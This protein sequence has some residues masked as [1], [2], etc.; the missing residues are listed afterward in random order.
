M[1]TL[2]AWSAD[3]DALAAW[4]APRLE[5]LGH[6]ARRSV[7]KRAT[8]LRREIEVRRPSRSDTGHP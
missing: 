6:D 8:R 4:L 1:E 5:A 3:D 7:A 2:A